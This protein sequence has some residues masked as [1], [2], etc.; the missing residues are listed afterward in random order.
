M[1]DER[2]GGARPPLRR[3]RAGQLFLDLDRVV[4]FRDPDAIRDAQHVAIDG[5]PRHAE[6]VTE[7][8][9]RRL[10]PDARQLDERFHHGRHLAAVLLDERVRHADDRP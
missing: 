1:E 7:N 9:V 6:R 3:Q 5:Q 4:A 2:V 8:D 10:P